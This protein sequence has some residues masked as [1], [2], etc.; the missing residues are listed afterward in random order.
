MENK[1]LVKLSGVS[2]AFTNERGQREWAFRDISFDVKRGEFLSMV[3][4]SGCGKSTLLR[5]L[6]GLTTM[7][8]GVI[9]RDFKKATIVF[10]NFALFPWLTV[11][12]NVEFGLAMESVGEHGI[13]YIF[14]GLFCHFFPC[15]T[16]LEVL[17]FSY[18]D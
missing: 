1:P 13:R 7:T 17:T 4:P 3:G 10:Q 2:H 12:K 15:T 8:E 16:R 11:Q 5:T 9:L 18:H 6:T 14:R